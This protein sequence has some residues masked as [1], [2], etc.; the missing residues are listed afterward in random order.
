MCVQ[1]TLKTESINADTL[2]ALNR[3][4]DLPTRSTRGQGILGVF[5]GTKTQPMPTISRGVV[6][7][8][9]KAEEQ[10]Y[11]VHNYRKTNETLTLT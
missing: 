9:E 4:G 2:I 6:E 5:D 7:E 8:F 10:H 3:S 11:E 1:F